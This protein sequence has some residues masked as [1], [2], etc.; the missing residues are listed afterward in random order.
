[1]LTRKSEQKN[2]G[3]KGV[4]IVLATMTILIFGGMIGLAIDGGIAFFLKARLG[5]A[6][7]AASLAGARTLARN[8]FWGCTVPTPTV[9]VWE[10][11]V[12]THIRYVQVTGS[13]TTPLYFM[14]VLGFTTASLSSTATAQRRDVNVMFVLDR[15]GSMSG[16]IAD[17]VNDSKWFVSNFALGRDRV[18]LVT[19]GGTY[20]LIKPTT[21]FSGVSTAISTLTA[22][23]VYGT[24]NHAQPLWTAYKALA[25]LN[26]PGS[27]NV[28][29]FFTDG[30][31]N[32]IF[33]DW[34]AY[35]KTP[36][37]CNN[38]GNG[39][40]GYAL[41]YSNN[42]LGG[43]FANLTPLPPYGPLN[44]LTA[45]TVG[46]DYVSTAY[47]KGTTTY[48]STSMISMSKTTG[49]TFLPNSPGNVAANFTQIPPFD[50]YGNATNPTGTPPNAGGPPAD[51]PTCT[52][53]YQSVTLNN[54]TYQ[55]LLAAAFNA[56]DSAAQRMRKGT[57]NGIIPLVDCIALNTGSTIDSVYM[58][59]LAN[60]TSS[61]V[62]YDNTKPTGIYVY[63]QSTSDLMPA[64]QQIAS[65][66]LHLSQ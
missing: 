55:N 8:N 62:P 20:Y 23:N 64:F 24:T 12:N 58:N 5:Q 42:T 11:T 53:R 29:V 37:T 15:S 43:L 22:S 47:D 40:R 27:L 4:A 17:L 50:Y 10:D 1:M 28:I 32:T 16:A 3:E 46:T 66:L 2:K 63:A 41:V 57:I 25:E 31:P 38:G 6:M 39:V 56:G 60:T 51:C 35:L 61:T 44:Q 54:F 19:F 59:R 21:A 48:D 18:G 49:C 65:Q 52:S 13:V 36:T 14:R 30:Q 9:A 26:E 34:Q 7:D 45:G 33:A